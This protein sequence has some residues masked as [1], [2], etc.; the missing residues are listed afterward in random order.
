[1]WQVLPFIKKQNKKQMHSFWYSSAFLSTSQAFEIIVFPCVK[2]GYKC[3]KEDKLSTQSIHL[4]HSHFTYLH[5]YVLNELGFSFVCMLQIVIFHPRQ[6]YIDS[7]IAYTWDYIIG[8]WIEQLYFGQDAVTVQPIKFQFS[9]VRLV[10]NEFWM[11]A[12]GY[13]TSLLCLEVDLT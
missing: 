12:V 9:V 1:M 2:L 8:Q 11:I 7:Q 5:A 6:I 4:S 3:S 10:K 13:I